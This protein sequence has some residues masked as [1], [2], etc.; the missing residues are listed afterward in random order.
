MDNIEWANINTFKNS[1]DQAPTDGAKAEDE[2]E[3]VEENVESD[4]ESTYSK[5]EEDVQLEVLKKMLV[6]LKPG[7]TVLKAIKRLGNTSKSVHSTTGLSAS[8]RWLKKKNQ[9]QQTNETQADSE[10]AKADKLALER[11][12]GH[13]NHFIDRGYYDVTMSVNHWVD[14]L[15]VKFFL[16]FTKK[17]LRS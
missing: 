5:E 2:D 14:F 1:K 13:A 8:Q 7:E 16:R 15:I 4:N 17:P 10:Q 11:L 9:P 12:T 3:E 6:Y